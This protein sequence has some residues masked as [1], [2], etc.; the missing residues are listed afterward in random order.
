MYA[1]SRQFL[2]I[3][4]FQS[5]GHFEINSTENYHQAC[6]LLLHSLKMNYTETLKL[7]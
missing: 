2:K 1:I 4:I 6:H 7:L 3:K 5:N